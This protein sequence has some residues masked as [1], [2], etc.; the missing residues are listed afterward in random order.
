MP[1]P[2]HSSAS[3]D[4]P[5]TGEILVGLGAD[6]FETEKLDLSNEDRWASVAGLAP[7]WETGYP[8]APPRGTRWN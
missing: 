2:R 7:Y 5:S 8:P 4:E 1:D 6:A 3:H